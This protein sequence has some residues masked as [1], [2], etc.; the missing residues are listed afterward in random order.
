MLERRI[1][2]FRSL[3][4]AALDRMALKREVDAIGRIRSD[5]EKDRASSVKPPSR[6]DTRPLGP[7]WACSEVSHG[8]SLTVRQ[9]VPPLCS[10]S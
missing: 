4:F 9:S 10:Q 8:S 2:L 7:A 5:N 6:A 3:P 1:R